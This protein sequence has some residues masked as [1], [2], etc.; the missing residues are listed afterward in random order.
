M[1]L[2]E[3]ELFGGTP[4]KKY[5]DILFVANRNLVEDNLTG[6]ID[7][8]AALEMLLEDI[9]GEDKDIL[10]LTK[11]YI[12]KNQDKINERRKNLMIEGMGD[13]VSRNE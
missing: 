5:F 3:D 1:F 6:L 12:F 8:T 7:H 4:E 11:N 9:L 13:I 10:E 2:E